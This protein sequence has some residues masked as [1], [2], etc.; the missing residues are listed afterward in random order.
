MFQLS[1]SLSQTISLLAPKEFYSQYIYLCLH[2]LHFMH[3]VK[4]LCVCVCVAPCC[5]AQGAL[6]DTIPLYS[7]L[8]G[9]HTSRCP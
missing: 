8:G 7:Y 4:L 2:K 5:A 9:V 3:S 1:N 6:A